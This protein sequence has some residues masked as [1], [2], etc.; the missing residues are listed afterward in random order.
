MQGNPELSLDAPL[1][2]RVVLIDMWTP[3]LRF[4]FA[5]SSLTHVP[6]PNRI[7]GGKH[8]R[9][10]VGGDGSMPPCGPNEIVGI[11]PF[12]QNY[13]CVKIYH[14]PEPTSLHLFVPLTEPFFFFFFSLFFSCFAQIRHAD[15]SDSVARTGLGVSQWCTRTQCSVHIHSLEWQC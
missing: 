12:S 3:R 1:G 7:G 10:S 8:R 15:E 11:A 2:G 5:L 14:A 13:R 4:C 6:R 9:A